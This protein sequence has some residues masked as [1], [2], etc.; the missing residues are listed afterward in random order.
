MLKSFF[1]LLASVCIVACMDV[2]SD[3]KGIERSAVVPDAKTGIEKAFENYL[4]SSSAK[5]HLQK[6]AEIESPPCPLAHSELNAS[7]SLVKR[8]AIGNTVGPHYGG[9]NKRHYTWS[10]IRNYTGYTP[11]G[12]GDA[13]VE[14]AIHMM[15]AMW[16]SVANISFEKSTSGPGDITFEW[17]DSLYY[18]CG[19]SGT[20][21]CYALN[22]G[23]IALS[24]DAA[25]I[26]QAT[27]LSEAYGAQII[28]AD[29]YRKPSGT[30]INIAW[31]TNQIIAS[32]L[33]E[34]GHFLGM[35]HAQD[36]ANYGSSA[37][38]GMSC[39]Q[40]QCQ[41]CVYPQP[42]DP[43]IMSYDFNCSEV[44]G[45]G[46]K[47]YLSAYDVY[48]METKYGS[49]QYG[50]PLIELWI[51]SWNKHYY[52]SRWEEANPMVYSGFASDVNWFPG[53]IMK[54]NV[55]STAAMHRHYTEQS[56][57]GS[58]HY[59][60]TPSRIYSPT[61]MWYEGVMGYVG[62]D[63]WGGALTPLYQHYSTGLKNH[64]FTSSST[65][66]GGYT[67]QSLFGYIVPFND[68][69]QAY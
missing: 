7:S 9:L 31:N 14:Q 64:M 54:S 48:V 61:P 37:T 21:T 57:V 36:D 63:S 44:P 42:N 11:D 66:P 24:K 5:T 39:Y 23:G 47:A 8:A 12:M 1:M 34:V 25:G 30:W 18:P 67:Y 62:T 53:M 15:L 59:Y 51:P 17:R 58:K 27:V 41:T 26:P 52:A 33:H 56:G 28:F 46:C 22:A 40:C 68:M 29:K 35:W 55:T 49:N 32:G 13:E 43:A 50:W 4:K 3:D 20:S 16:S 45:V 69:F 10:I 19:P 38:T 65:P 2:T 60:T 6:K